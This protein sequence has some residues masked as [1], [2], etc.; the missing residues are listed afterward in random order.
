MKPNPKAPDMIVAIQHH[1]ARIF[2]IDIHSHEVT[3]NTIKPHDPHHF[4]HHLTHKNEDK[5]AGQRASEDPA[6]YEQIS[7]ELAGGNRI[8]IVGHGTGHSNAGHHLAEH[9]RAKHTETAARMHEVS[10][11]LSAVTDNQLLALGREAL[12]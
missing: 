6:F 9:L 5:E 12:H 8:V 1:E 7:A 2:Q 11:D 10:A 4:R 3:Q